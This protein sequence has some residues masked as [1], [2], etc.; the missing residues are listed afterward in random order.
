[1]ST[2]KSPTRREPIPPTPPDQ[3]RPYARLTVDELRDVEGLTNEEW[4]EELRA[5]GII[6]GGT[7]G[8]GPLS[9]KP[10]S[11]PVPPGALQRFLKERA[12]SDSEWHRHD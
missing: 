10:V 1:M 6:Q 4:F 8:P 3:P 2:E 5:R 7:K 11:P 9:L 12:V